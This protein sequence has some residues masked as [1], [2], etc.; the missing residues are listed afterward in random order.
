MNDFYTEVEN[1]IISDY[2]YYY[3]WKAFQGK[4]VQSPTAP[5]YNSRPVNSTTSRGQTVYDHSKILRQ[6]NQ[7]KRI[8]HKDD[9]I[10]LCTNYLE[11]GSFLFK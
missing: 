7:K 4:N 8:I 3:C 11:N 9:T 5:F 1:M 6:P 10:H 2:Y